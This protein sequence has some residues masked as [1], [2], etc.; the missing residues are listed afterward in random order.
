MGNS[1]VWTTIS[2]ES[3][4][5][6]MATANS[7]VSCNLIF[8]LRYFRCCITFSAKSRWIAAAHGCLWMRFEC[9]FT[10]N[11]SPMRWQLAKSYST[12]LLL[13]CQENQSE[14][15]FM[16]VRAPPSGFA[17]PYNFSISLDLWFHSR[18]WNVQHRN[19]FS[20]S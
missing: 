11:F 2:V 7:F 13:L 14:S 17:V 20:C 5:L 10:K 9:H 3:E 16:W 19:V 1:L 4:R 12:L 18:T 15:Y 8:Q 6:S